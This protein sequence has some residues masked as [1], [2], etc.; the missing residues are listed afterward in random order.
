MFNSTKPNERAD[1]TG[2]ASGASAS[3]S[4]L[5]AKGVK[6]EG[7]FTSQSDVVIEGEVHG[8]LKTSGKLTV[9]TDA[10]ILADV[11]AG[12]AVVAGSVQGN[13]QVANRLE[14]KS[15]AKIIGD[16]SAEIVSIE[17][18]AA[19]SGRVSIGAKPQATMTP[20]NGNGRSRTMSAPKEV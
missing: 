20:V 9:G 18:G 10:K 11:T 15:S 4:T 2:Y 19:L 6:M 7:D 3:S 17:G 5:I 1:A 12:D 8:T 16:I 14:V 13:L